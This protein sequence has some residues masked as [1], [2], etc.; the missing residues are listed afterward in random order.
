VKSPRQDQQYL[1]SYLPHDQHNRSAIHEISTNVSSNHS[2][3]QRKEIPS[4]KP[5]QF[6]SYK[7]NLVSSTGQPQYHQHSQGSGGNQGGGVQTYMPI[8]HHQ[9]EIKRVFELS[10]E[11]VLQ[12]LKYRFLSSPTNA[13]RKS[14]TTNHQIY[15]Q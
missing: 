5:F 4:V 7:G 15:E 8:Q 9:H 1:S 10:N 6:D 14:G 11:E 13:G 3:P 12:K 2:D